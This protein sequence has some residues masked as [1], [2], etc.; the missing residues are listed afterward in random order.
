MPIVQGNKLVRIHRHGSIGKDECLVDARA[1]GRLRVGRIHQRGHLLHDFWSRLPGR[2]T[3]QARRIDHPGLRRR[4][5]TADP[6]QDPPLGQDG[7]LPAC[8][9]KG[10]KISPQHAQLR[11]CQHRSGTLDGVPV[12]PVR[13]RAGAG[14]PD[15]RRVSGHRRRGLSAQAFGPLLSVRRLQD[16]QVRRGR[17]KGHSRPAGLG[18]MRH[19][20][21][22]GHSGPHGAV[23]RALR[24]DEIEGREG[25]ARTG[26]RCSS[27]TTTNNNNGTDRLRKRIQ[28]NIFDNQL[29]Q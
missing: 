17:S 5:P 11:R 10:P 8:R 13:G 26:K 7:N 24:A 27:G 16:R 6:T 23:D 21:E 1:A 19:A 12:P 28:M 2:C 18:R 20:D 9:R 29:N 4:I 22:A 15:H 14:V 25:T 3:R